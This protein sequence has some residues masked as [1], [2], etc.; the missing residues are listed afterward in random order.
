MDTVAEDI[1]SQSEVSNW[2]IENQHN[3]IGWE[4]HYSKEIK[5]GEWVAYNNFKIIVF[6]MKDKSKK[7]FKTVHYNQTFKKD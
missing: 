6:N 4:V 7:E 1:F 3:I 5:K 2:E